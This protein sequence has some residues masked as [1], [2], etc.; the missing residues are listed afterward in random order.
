MARLKAKVSPTE[1]ISHAHQHTGV[2]RICLHA[3]L[4]RETDIF[5]CSKTAISEL[6]QTNKQTNNWVHKLAFF[7]FLNPCF[8][9][10]AFLPTWF[11]QSCHRVRPD[12]DI[13]LERY[14]VAHQSTQRR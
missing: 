5:P 6:I 8:T 12:D 13:I 11:T 2:R 9:Q 7:F 3:Q 4:S 1:A 14:R 10:V